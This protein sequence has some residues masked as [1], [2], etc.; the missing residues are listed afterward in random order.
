[1]VGG[2]TWAAVLYPT[3]ASAG[4]QRKGRVAADPRILLA[5]YTHHDQSWALVAE[6]QNADSGICQPATSAF[7]IWDL[8]V[9]QPAA[10]AFDIWDRGE[11]LRPASTFFISNIHQIQPMHLISTFFIS[12]YLLNVLPVEG[13]A[14]EED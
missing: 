8:R 6:M 11:I 3:T 10:S 5:G 4:E 13:A 12:D 14:M 7:D 9:V 1:M 2:L